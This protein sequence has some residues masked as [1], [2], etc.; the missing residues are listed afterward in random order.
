M[1]DRRSKLLSSVTLLH[2]LGMTCV[3]FVVAYLLRSLLVHLDFFSRHLP[4][5]Y[6]FSHYLPLL[7]AFLITWAAVG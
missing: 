2:D 3:S 5:I 6:P 1:F 4:G 7:A